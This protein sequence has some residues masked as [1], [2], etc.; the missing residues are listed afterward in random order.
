MYNII[1]VTFVYYFIFY[2]V[3][4]HTGGPEQELLTKYLLSRL[5]EQGDLAFP[6]LNVGERRADHDASSSIVYPQRIRRPLQKLV[7][8]AKENIDVIDFRNPRQKVRAIKYFVITRHL[9]SC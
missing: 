2:F 8:Q 9:Q 7:D 5:L 6:D 4:E 1:T 3:T